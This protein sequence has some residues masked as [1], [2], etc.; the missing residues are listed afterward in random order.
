[1]FLFQ[2]F[3]CTLNRFLISKLPLGDT[4]LHLASRR[5]DPDLV[6]LLVDHGANVDAANEEGQT[7]LHVAAVMGDEPNIRSQ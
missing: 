1:M 4:C 6:K 5:R 3:S 7:V 2:P